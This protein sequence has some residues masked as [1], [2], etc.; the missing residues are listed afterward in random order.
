MSAVPSPEVGPSDDVPLS[1]EPVLGWR[2]W[3]LT[4]ERGEL[5]LQALAHPDTWTPNDATA[6]RC[7]RAPHLGAPLESCTC[8]YYA[9]SSV[10]NLAAAGVFDRRVGVIGAIAM[11]GTVVEHHRGARS[12]YA[13]PARLRLVC[14]P[15][16]QEGRVADPEEVVG[17][18]TY[19]VPMC[20]SHLKKEKATGASAAE[21]Q[22]EL[23][24]TY[25]VEVLPK[26]KIPRLTPQRTP[27]SLGLQV[28]KGIFA[29]IRFAI[30]ALFMLWAFSGILFIALAIATGVLGAIFGWNHPDADPSAT[31]VAL[32]PPP[33]LVHADRTDKHRR[34][35]PAAPVPKFAVKCGI[36]HGTWIEF[37]PCSLPAADLL[38]F[39]EGTSPRGAARDCPPDPDAYSY[40]DDWNVCWLAMPG[41]W[42]SP[43]AT[44]SNPFHHARK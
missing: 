17:N 38:G 11:W 7:S 39:A 2:V 27:T 35:P 20:S 19:L 16:V 29:V 22:S 36:S 14:G 12:E 43:T 30:G 41:T 6:A 32:A 13:Y 5:R 8:G 1:I 9:A 37:A 44:S 3:R 4:R 15:C 28:G 42:V 31:A 24:S 34:Q 40:G 23:L 10:E 18:D 21:V 26:P 33:S 25:A